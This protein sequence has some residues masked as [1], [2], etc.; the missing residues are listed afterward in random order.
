[1]GD[2]FD[3]SMIHLIGGGM[4]VNVSCPELTK[5]IARHPNC[6]A[7]VSGTL[8][9][10]VVVRHL[11]KGDPSGCFRRA[12]RN[13]CFRQVDEKIIEKYHKEP[14]LPINMEFPNIGM[15]V[16]NPSKDW[17]ELVVASNFAL[18]WLAKEGHNG[19]VGINFLEKAQIPLV[20]SIYGAM[21]AG[22]D[23]I[24][25]GAGIPS[26][27]PRI[28]DR[29]S[30]HEKVE[31]RVHVDRARN[32]E[33]FCVELDPANVFGQDIVSQLP[34][35]KRPKF[36]PIVSSHILADRL[37]GGS[38]AFVIEGWNAGGHSAGPREKG[39]FS[40]KG[41]PIYG[42]KDVPNLEKIRQIGK[43]FF[44]ADGFS[45]PEKLAEA[46]ARGA[47]GV[48]IGSVA[49]LSRESGILDEYKKRMLASA[50]QGKLRVINDPL[51][52]PSGFPFK[53]VSMEGTLSDEEIYTSRIRLCDIGALR[54]PYRKENGEIG[55]RC[56][57]E[58]QEDYVRKGG[59]IEDTFGCKC[60]C[61]GL[62][63]DVGLG[64]TRKDGYREPPIL[65]M[66]K[67]LS[68]IPRI[69]KKPEPYPIED[70]IKF[71]LGY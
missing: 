71:I 42:E 31:Y 16:I 53:V 28:L 30:R 64:K 43:P 40:E 8:A 9:A 51:V 62:P 14:E 7:V 55:Y 41:E 25:I 46:Q 57:A 67:D 65:T 68:F 60:L 56:P 12:L 18:V 13:F 54:T 11:H 15:P 4:G 66:G 24:F 36:I 35:M 20:F 22:V 58:P 44:L 27:V 21:L 37:K 29:L 34:I 49:A 5:E 3:L 33:M 69:A 48:Q 45:T 1:M 61:N 10:E 6:L 26:Q 63:A 23:A 52:S 70:V 19:F 38:D 39:H 2:D 32:G 50:L 59:K 47:A 17:V